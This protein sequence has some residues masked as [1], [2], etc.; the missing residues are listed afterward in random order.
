M[1]DGSSGLHRRPPCPGHPGV[2]TVRSSSRQQDALPS[3]ICLFTSSEQRALAAEDRSHAALDLP[4]VGAIPGECKE[5]QRFSAGPL[6]RGTYA[7][8][9]VNRNKVLR[10]G[11]FHFR[12]PAGRLSAV[13]RGQSQQLLHQGR[14]FFE[15]ARCRLYQRP[16][17]QLARSS[18]ESAIT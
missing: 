13:P 16:G 6:E 1:N 11:P 14:E 8:P 15:I 4:G 2:F 18:R 5:L 10:G 9:R 7:K 3:K 17:A 12:I